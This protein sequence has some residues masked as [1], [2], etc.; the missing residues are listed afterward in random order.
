MI[1]NIRRQATDVVVWSG[2]N[3]E[4][5]F[6]LMKE[7]QFSYDKDALWLEYRQLPDQRD[8][9]I[10]NVKAHSYQFVRISSNTASMYVDAPSVTASVVVPGVR[11]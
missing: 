9:L 8:H 11:R 6:E 3:E 7:I 10:L 5:F 2:L 4:D 1:K